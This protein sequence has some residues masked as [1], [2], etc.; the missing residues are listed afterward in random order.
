MSGNKHL[1]SALIVSISCFLKIEFKWRQW[2]S[3]S[4]H[5]GLA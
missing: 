3:I 1:I 2:N 4:E 5:H